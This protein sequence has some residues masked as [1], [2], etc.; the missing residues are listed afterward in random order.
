[1]RRL[2]LLAAVFA[3]MLIAGS[4]SAAP[5]M[6]TSESIHHNYFFLGDFHTYDY[7]STVDFY[8]QHRN[9]V[10]GGYWI[11]NGSNLNSSMSWGHTLPSDLSVPPDVIDRARL[12]I[13]AAW[14]DSR[15]N[16]IDIEGTMDWDPLSRRFLDNTTYDLAD[17]EVPGF[18]NDGILN[19]SIMAGEY[20][21]RIDEAILMI[22]YTNGEGGGDDALATVPEPTTIG[23]LLMGLVGMGAE[24]RRRRK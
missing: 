11:G 7:A 14:V 3:L 23:L 24:V 5:T 18:W 15:G 16:T 2:T 9:G 6:M 1:M 20:S 12:W 17:V 19:V 13:D 8:T 10:L 4:V 22:D 21:L